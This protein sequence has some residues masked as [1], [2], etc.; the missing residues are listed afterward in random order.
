MS[1]VIQG[2]A[3]RLYLPATKAYWQLPHWRSLKAILRA[4]ILELQTVSTVIQGPVIRLYLPATKAYWQ[5]PHWRSLTAILRADILELQAVSTVIQGP[6]R[7]RELI[8]SP[9]M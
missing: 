3:I 7:P 6:V 5:L 9:A 8:T 2:P 1:T 4:D